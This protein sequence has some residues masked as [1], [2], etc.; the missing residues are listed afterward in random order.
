MRKLFTAIA[1]VFFLVSCA[2]EK[3]VTVDHSMKVEFGHD[4]P[5]GESLSVTYLDFRGREVISDEIIEAIGSVPSDLVLISCDGSVGSQD[6]SE[7]LAANCSDWGHD[8]FYCVDGHMGSSSYANAYFE[9]VELSSGKNLVA[10]VGGCSF[11]TGDV[12]SSGKEIIEN[13]IQN[14]QTGPWVLILPQKSDLLT[15]YTFTDC[16]AA[17]E[18]VADEGVIRGH[19]VYASDGMWSRMSYIEEEPLGFSVNVEQE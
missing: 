16:F 11:M 4:M 10:Q 3:E 8:V 18:G 1:V 5:Q 13:T 14:G 2:K 7:W 9:A 6:A 17:Q 15:D 12:P 19:Y